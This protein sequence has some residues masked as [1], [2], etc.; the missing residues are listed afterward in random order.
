MTRRRL[1][2]GVVGGLVTVALGVSLVG[3]KTHR[4]LRSER[5]EEREF[6]YR[7][8]SSLRNMAE[9]LHEWRRL[10]LPVFRQIGRRCV[11]KGQRHY[12]AMIYLTNEAMKKCNYSDAAQTLYEASADIDEEAFWLSKPR[13]L[14]VPNC[15][16]KGANVEVFTGKAQCICESHDRP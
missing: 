7:I 8:A 15:W 3:L 6:C 9:H 12:Q 14:A 13:P 10:P 16:P 11:N 5:L 2:I 1:R 4:Q